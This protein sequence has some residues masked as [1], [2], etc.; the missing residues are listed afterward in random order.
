MK[1]DDL[2]IGREQTKIKHF[3]LQQYLSRFAH[4]IGFRWDTITYVDC[5]SGPWN[6]QSPDLRD[7]S[8]SIAIKELRRAQENRPCKLGRSA[9]RV[10]RLVG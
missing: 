6:V 1:Q 7:S 4:I 10:A 2:Y 9:S 8:F 5:F 3:I